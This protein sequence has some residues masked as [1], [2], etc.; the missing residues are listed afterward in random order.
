MDTYGL[1]GH[2]LHFHVNRVN[3]W[4]DG[5]NIYPLYMEISPTGACNHRC[6]FCGLD[7]M[8]Y[9]A[10]ILD[11]GLL[12]E[13]LSELGALGLK[14]VMYAG[15][16]EPLLHKG[17]ADIVKHTKRSGIDVAITTNAVL[18]DKNFAETCLGSL[19]WIKVS[20]NA[21]IAETYRSIHKAKQGDFE[22][23]ISNMK[24][25]R[26]LKEEGGHSCA[27]GM[28][29]ILLPENYNEA[30]TLAGIARDIGMDYLVIKPYSQH[31]QSITKKYETISYA[32]IETLSATLGEYNNGDFSTVI[33][34]KAIGKEKK[35]NKGYSRCLA[36]PFWS[37][38]DS[39]GRVWGCS[40]F[41]EDERFYYGNIYENSFK[42]IWEGERRAKSIAFVLNE[43]DASKCRLNCRMDAVN[44]YLWGL[45][46]P[47]P[48]VNFI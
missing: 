40:V 28:Q 2:K 22:R 44:G 14:S 12:K 42:E 10:T 46:E 33:R 32:D 11:S 35:E 15:E 29:M 26:K 37:Y 19:E 30:T 34:S 39:K 16:G 1:D 31:P 5:K 41:L 45:E 3:E 23:V 36:L 13:R 18:L 9:E 7:F 38:I 27:L 47:P 24:T 48:H 43:F 17:L 21:G 25:A 8:G 6:E 20:I 4:L